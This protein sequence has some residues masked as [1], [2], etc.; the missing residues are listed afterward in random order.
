M[1]RLSK[2]EQ[3]LRSGLASVRAECFRERPAGVR[4]PPEYSGRLGFCGGL[5][6]PL[7]RP[8]LWVLMAALSS[9]AGQLSTKK[10]LRTLSLGGGRQPKFSLD[11]SAAGR[12][13]MV[14]V[15]TEG[16]AR[17][18]TL[19]C[20]L[21]RDWGSTI[22]VNDDLTARVLDYHAEV[23]VSELK[24]TDVD[25]DGL[26]DILAP[27]DF[28]AKWRKY[29]VWL[30]SPA[31]GKFIRDP[32]SQQ[33]ED[34]VNLTVDGK[35]HQIVSFTIGPVNPTRSEYR[36][37]TRSE[38]NGSRALSRVRWC[39]LDTGATE[40]AVRIAT[41]VRYLN[42]RETTQHRIVS[43]DC[44]DVCGDLCPTVPRRKPKHP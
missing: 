30:F 12:T 4:N 9:N 37:E 25:F 2:P 13:G 38:I 17:V 6:P 7:Y 41:T 44:N 26:S 39:E 3:T 24:I 1:R 27:R 16:G 32:L 35:Q 31:Q 14:S 28:G 29:C 15:R 11:V 5:I 34:L 40:G 42:G 21:F 36:I 22:A 10:H 33:M 18:Q 8:L 43:A 23:F 19:T 20:D